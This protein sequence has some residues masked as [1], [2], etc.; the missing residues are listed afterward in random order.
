MKS[1]TS[2]RNRLGSKTPSSITW[3]SVICGS[4]SVS[5]VTVRQGLNHSLPEVSVP[6]RAS[7]PSETTRASFIENRVGSSDL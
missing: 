2:A 1:R 7:L 6:T 5:P 3:S 4:A